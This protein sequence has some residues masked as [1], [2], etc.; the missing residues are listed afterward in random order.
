MCFQILF[1]PI[2]SDIFS[3][4]LESAPPPK[5]PPSS[6][7]ICDN[8]TWCSVEKCLITYNCL[9][10]V[11]PTLTEFLCEFSLLR[12]GHYISPYTDKTTNV[13]CGSFHLKTR[14]LVKTIKALMTLVSQQIC[15]S[16]L[17]NTVPPP[18]IG[19]TSRFAV[20]NF[21]IAVFYYAKHGSSVEETDRCWPFLSAVLTRFKFLL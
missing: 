13:Y 12:T 21:R 1:C 15:L 14:L 7:K 6:P 5:V 3:Y 18:D 8:I 20:H 10:A 11:V 4:L 19:T 9:T 17:E 16:F 2:V